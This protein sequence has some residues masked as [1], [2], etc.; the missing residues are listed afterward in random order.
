MGHGRM[1]L[2]GISFALL[3]VCR[4]STAQV[5]TAR[6]DGIVRDPSGAAVP[7]AS[8]SAVN[9]RTQIREETST[10]SEGRF[11]FP[12][13][14]P[15]V[16]EL[17]VKAPGFRTAV[18]SNLELTV[19]ATREQDVSLEL[20]NPNE[21]IVVQAAAERVQVMDAQIAR[22]V[23]LRDIEV[24][25]QVFSTPMLLAIFSAGV[26]VV[27]S[28]IAASRV[29][30]TRQ[31]ST[32]SRLDGIDVNDSATPFMLLSNNANNKDSIEEF[33]IVT[34]G[35]KAE[36]GRNAGGQIE[37]I[38][39]SGT[40]AWHGN[41]FEYHRNTALNAN[42]F[43]GNAQDLEQSK[44]I[45]NTF[46][47][48]LG[49]PIRGDRT[50]I[51]GNFQGQ[52]NVE[53]EV[54]N[55]LVLMDDAKRGV[56][57]WRPPGSS[58][59]E[60][61]DIAGNDPRDIGIDPQVAEIL[62]LLP[63]HNNHDI[64]DGLNTAGFRFNNPI[65]TAGDSNGNQFTIKADHILWSGH[66]LFF[67]WTWARSSFI[68]SLNG[69]DARFPGQ[70]PGMQRGGDWG[71][72]IGS[73]WKI[74]SRLWNELRVGYKFYTWEFNRPARL[75]KPM[76]L[77]NSWTDPLNPTFGIRREPPV[78][79]ITDNLTIVRGRHTFKS[80]L[81]WRFTREWRSLDGLI[82]PNVTFATSL[83]NGVPTTIGPSKPT[84]SDDDRKSFDNLYNDLLGRMNQVAQNFYSDQSD[85]KSF[86]PDETPRVRTHRFREFSGFFQDDWKLHPRLVVNLGLR[87]EFFGVPFEVN[88][89]QGIVDKAALINSS[90]RLADL[91]IQPGCHWY[92][93]DFNNFAPRIGLAWDP[94]GDG[95]TS[96]RANWGLFYDRLIGATTISVDLRTPGYTYSAFAYPN[97]PGTDIRVSDG[98]PRPPRPAVPQLRPPGDRKTQLFLFSPNLRTGY[99]QHYSLTLQREIF[100]NTVIEAG[101]VGTHGIKLFMD[102]NLN[103]P[104]IYED[105]LPAFR[106][107]QAFRAQGTPVPPSNTLVKIF[108]STAKAITALA[109]TL[110]LGAAGIAADAM[111]RLYYSRYAQAGVSDFYLRNFPQFN[112]VV[113][114]TNDGRSYYDS[115][116][117]SLRRQTGALKFAA[118]Y[119]FSKSM[120]NIS[121][122][123]N[124][125]TSPIDNFNVRL[126]RARGDLDIPHAFNA[127]LVYTLPVG[128]D[129]H[130]AGNAPRW[131][132][133][134]IGGWD[135]GLLMLW[136]SGPVVT[137]LSGRSTG[138]TT[139]SSYVDYSGDRNIGKVMRKTDGVY[140]L[141]EE[142]KNRFSHPE[143]GEI[144]T[145]GRNAFRGPRCF[146]VDMSLVK[147]FKIGERHAVSFRV[148][149]Y[150][151]F[152][153]VN[154]APPN[155]DLSMPNS[156]GQIAGTVGKARFLQL[157]LR[158]EF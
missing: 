137:Y 16:Y 20:G 110:D 148:E 132:D 143:A 28:M 76:L 149:A 157:A 113:V 79:Q 120:D 85:L 78:R 95:K 63:D 156:F 114:G 144:G 122:D 153:N 66:R 44:Y 38:T 131:V 58:K 53:E 123:G 54:R 36:Y 65:T 158:Y 97:S 12:S 19:G 15:G 93:N 147:K 96:L 88:G 103:Q 124:G 7:G 108:G 57:S 30:G 10:T 71:Y 45:Q 34:S 87:Y 119:T 101:Y 117:L 29:N 91:T 104:R 39:R 100:R 47:A 128:K 152:N 8:V 98:I 32:N 17:S 31:G 56:F 83:G 59:I 75:P 14:Q 111:D 26:Q 121:V 6:L 155:T 112:Q 80:G 25:P 72:S 90:A 107:L 23:T 73:D 9:S 27:A 142:Q 94:A 106:E 68:D 89:I 82:W 116:Q 22:A 21:E 154:F 52:R 125:F 140:W 3:L 135:I 69:N 126:N 61:F 51:F 139:G 24:L 105:F 50:F 151:L 77:A 40:N 1:C 48:S 118:N 64:G 67:R 129:H 60:T 133:S 138:P 33:R 84:I 136:Q 11:A 150:N 46:G 127:S 35:G 92:D 4:I 146:N 18:V 102:L 141:T 62:K 70:P 49:G 145:G 81:E 41:A 43:F 55:R 134:L 37:L 42:S 2:R 130:F 13:L 5:A 74:T 109:S 99:V 115:F 86:Q